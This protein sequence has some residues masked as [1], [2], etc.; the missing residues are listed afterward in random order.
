MGALA[1]V[2]SFLMRQHVTT[3]WLKL[4]AVLRTTQRE[5][6]G[7]QATAPQ[8]QA[9]NSAAA[10][11]PAV[12]PC[13]LLDLQRLSSLSALVPKVVVLRDR[14]RPHDDTVD[15]SGSLG[16]GGLSN[17][18]GGT[19]PDG[20]RAAV[21]ACAEDDNE[22]GFVK[23]NH[24]GGCSGRAGQ[25]SAALPDMG[26]EEEPSSSLVVDLVDPGKV[27]LQAGDDGSTAAFP[28]VASA[29]RLM[30]QSGDI[31]KD[32]AERCVAALKRSMVAAM[33]LIQ[34]EMIPPGLPYDK[35][36]VRNSIFSLMIIP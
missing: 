24:V 34:S 23:D 16:V 19:R 26:D 13:D 3:T 5:A 2:H 27:L 12:L 8:R 14:A 32:K 10:S 31:G 30:M 17:L 21:R 33:L 25:A 36:A 4:A 6:D 7:S 9:A 18:G 15:L 1:Q 11:E 29:L 28:A 35:G 22:G 20:E